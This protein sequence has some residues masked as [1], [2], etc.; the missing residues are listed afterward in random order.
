MFEISDPMPDIPADSAM[1]IVGKRYSMLINQGAGRRIYWFLFVKL[2]NTTVGLYETIP[3]FGKE[4]E[5]AMIQQYGDARITD[6]V[7]LKGLY[8]HRRAATVTALPE[9][10]FSKWHFG[11]I[12]ITGDA[13]H[14]V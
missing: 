12:I 8:K 7:T 3:R 10:V 4:D 1:Q 6:K 13:A 2:E 5:I 11:R 14:K 9:F